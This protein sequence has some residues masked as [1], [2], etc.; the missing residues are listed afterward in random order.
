MTVVVQHN[1]SLLDIAIQETGTAETVVAIAIANNISVTQLLEVG[2][3]I[4]I[5]EDVVGNNEILKYYKKNNIK[6]VTGKTVS[7]GEMLFERGLFEAGLFQ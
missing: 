5:P 1:Q 6:P 4:V 2:A 7:D 3:E